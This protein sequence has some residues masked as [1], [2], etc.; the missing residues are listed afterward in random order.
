MS[1]DPYIGPLHGNRG[2][3]R[4]RPGAPAG[5]TVAISREA[6]ASGGSIARRV[7]QRLGWQVYTREL[8][9][10]LCANEAAR[11]SVLADVPPEAAEWVTGQLDRLRRD[12]R[13]PREAEADEM[14]RLV[15]SLAAR[16][17]ALLVGCGAGYCLPRETS[18]HVRI[19]AERAN[20][21]AHMADWLRL[22]PDEA[23]RQ[24][25]QRDE[26]RAEFLLK[27]FGMR[28][29]EPYDFD[30]ILNS[31][32]LSEETCTDAILAAL[33][34]KESDGEPDTRLD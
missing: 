1:I 7:G 31:G 26:R 32:L 14:P 12:P 30:L 4:D 24:V 11:Q 25:Q 16:G 23:G 2:A 34:G 13:R 22:S 19:I 27:H 18:L 21:V 17:Q 20:R 33:K 29:A 5:L 3:G 6:G 9:E 28:S 8:L 15:L 10:F